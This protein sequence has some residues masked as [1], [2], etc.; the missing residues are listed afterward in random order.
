M[1]TYRPGYFWA[2]VDG[3]GWYAVK[4]LGSGDGLGGGV[5]ALLSHVSVNEEVC[6]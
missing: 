2:T 5:V 1:S 6:R 4:A 3:V